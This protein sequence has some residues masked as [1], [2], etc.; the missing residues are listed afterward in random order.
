MPVPVG[1][2]TDEQLRESCRY[3]AGAL[4]LNRPVAVVRAPRSRHPRRRMIAAALALLMVPALAAPAVSAALDLV[5][6]PRAANAVRLVPAVTTAALRRTAH[7]TRLEAVSAT[8]SDEAPLLL[9]QPPDDRMLRGVVAHVRP[10]EVRIVA[11]LYV[12]PVR[13]GA[14]GCLARGWYGSK[15]V[16]GTAHRLTG[17]GHFALQ[18]Q[19]DISSDHICDEL[20]SRVAVFA[21]P[22]AFVPP[23]LAAED[24]LPA[25]IFDAAIADVVID[26]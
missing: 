4:G 1:G 18:W 10:S 3:I 12:D 17:S 9:V 23:A 2:V 25:S 24:V 11:Y 22:S 20:A 15:P 5:G 6:L 13:A 14:R 26:R 19:S 7:R 16:D 21:V 8:L